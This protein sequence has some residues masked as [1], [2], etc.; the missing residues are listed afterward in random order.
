MREQRRHL[1]VLVAVAVEEPPAVLV[2]RRPDAEAVAP[3]DR[4]DIRFGHAGHRCAVG[5]DRVEERLRLGDPDF[6][7]PAPQSWRAV[8]GADH[9]RDDQ[10]EQRRAEPDRSEHLEDAEPLQRLDDT[11]PEQGVVAQVEL[12][13]REAVVPGRAEGEIGQLLDRHPDDR[14]QDD[15]DDLGDREVDRG[16]QAPQALPDPGDGVRC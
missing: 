8:Q 5:Q 15:D 16:Q 10:H 4:A 13:H 14:E 12:V 9:D 11:R 2:G 3:Q 1:R 6:G 7:D